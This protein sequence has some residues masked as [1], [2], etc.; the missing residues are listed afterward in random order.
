MN[1]D[2]SGVVESEGD[3][4]QQRHLSCSWSAAMRVSGQQATRI[5]GT[6]VEAGEE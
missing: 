2:E 3:N 1:A 4:D 5:T 6:G